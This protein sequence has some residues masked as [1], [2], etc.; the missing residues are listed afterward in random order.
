MYASSATGAYRPITCIVREKAP[1][2]ELVQQSKS[3]QQCMES[4]FFKP[5]RDYHSQVNILVGPRIIYP[6]M[7]LTIQS[8]EPMN[9]AFT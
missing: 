4:S 5:C 9:E 8:L 3:I 1:E 7:F 2:E 6:R